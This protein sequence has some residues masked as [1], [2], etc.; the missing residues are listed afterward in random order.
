MT[1]R[2]LVFFCL[3][4][5][6]IACKDTEKTISSSSRPQDPWVFRSV[7]DLKPRMLTL[8]L[9]DKIWV[10]YHTEH[11][12]IYKA[13]NGIV[14][15]DGAV[16][17]EQHGPQP[18]SIGDG[19]AVSKYE[20]PWLILENG[21]DTVQAIVNYKGHKFVGDHVQLMYEVSDSMHK[22]IALVTEEVEAIADKNITLQRTFSIKGLKPGIGLGLMTNVSS[23][24]GK[25]SIVTSGNYQ[26]TNSIER[27]FATDKKCL[28]IEGILLLNNGTTTFN[29]DFMQTPTIKNTNI[30]GGNQEK[31]EEG[32]PYG[33]TLISKSD[34]KT[35]HNKNLKTVG[36]SYAMIAEKYN[37]D[38]STIRSLVQK[39]K[40]GGNGVWGNVAM[41][42]HADLPED[43]IKQMVE[44]ILSLDVASDKKTVS[45]DAAKNYTHSTID[46]N[47]FLPGAIT[48]VYDAKAGIDKLPDFSKLKLK[49]AGIKNNFDN[50]DGAEF[51]DLTDNFALSAEGYLK[52]N[53]AGVYNFELWSD[54]GSKLYIHDELLIDN[55]GSHGTEGKFGKV[56]LDVGYHP[57]KMEYFQG[58]GGKYLSLDWTKPGDKAAEVIP[59]ENIFHMPDSENEFSKY[60][61]PMATASKI[62]GNK[63]ILAGV[64][65]AFTLTQARPTDFKPKVGGMDFLKDGSL[66]V[67]TWDKEGAVWKISNAQSGNP[68][69][70]KAT[71]IAFGLA[72]PL[73]VKVVDDTIYVMQKQEL[74]KLVDTNGDGIMDEYLTL[75]NDW[76]VS[77]NFHEFGFGLEYKDG[78]FYATLA[79]A[80]VPGG[81]SVDPQMKDRG[82]VIKINKNTGALSFIASGLRTPNGIGLGYNNELFVADNQGDWLPSSKIVHITDGA[83]YGSRSVDPEGTKLL[84]EKPPVVWLPQDEIGNSP[85]TPSYINVGPYK[86]QMI[87]GEVTHGGIK[88]VFVEEVNGVL[89]GAVFRFTQGLEAGVNRIKWGPDGALYIGGIGNPGNWAQASK[90]WYG[91]QRLAY[92][93]KSVFEMLAVRAKANGVE[94]EFTEPL[95]KGEGLDPKNYEILQWYYKPTIAYGGPKLG[96]A[97]LPVKSVT[98]SDDRKKV[99]LE[100]SGLKAGH[101]VYVHLI[102]GIISEPGNTLWS[103]EAWYTM[104]ELSKEKG[105][106]VKSTESFADNSLTNQEKA[107]GWQ[108]LFDGKKIDQFKNFRKPSIGSGWVI[109]D[110]AIHLNAVKENG[111][112]QAKDGGD[113]ITKEAYENYELKLEW[114]ITNCGN[115][116]IIFNV[117]ESEKYDYVWQTGPEMQVLDNTCHP[118]SR[119][120]SHRAG[121]L[122]DMIESI[123]PCAKPA[124]EWNKVTI[125]NYK[126]KVDFYLNGYKTVSF[127]MHTDDWKK[128][129]AKSKF[130]DM[131]GFGLAKIGHIALQDHGDKVWY[132]NIKIKKLT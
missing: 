97:K 15:F 127:T 34:C 83:W 59:A 67:S 22:V 103:T 26:I 50:I 72:E 78:F 39:V 119:Y 109:N 53:K 43:D 132:K 54:D 129:V 8:A 87:H 110:N 124:G 86:G 107:E 20:K 36:P 4:L 63:A 123:Y 7:L 116:G 88:R 55:D 92:N 32:L 120:I 68:S 75:C 66:I 35:C 118:D 71:R 46:T 13:W 38:E 57:F 108:L 98:I 62:P 90:Q 128:M 33:A 25:E 14:Y 23:I 111:K 44:Y 113:I 5:S 2:L 79:T 102:N 11:G 3:T 112:W 89:Q 17:T 76:K 64:H 74:T 117:V 52:I 77:S 115:S 69:K 80:I 96:E 42:A 95:S 40:N 28:D 30:A 85:S 82:K 48:K 93:G 27:N 81:A 122:Y 49:Q 58:G 41:S 47:Q 114:K 84:K 9:N 1:T 131:P 10:A 61:L 94:I 106:I 99:F 121:D 18:L 31:E 73:G 45:N 12:A 65:P 6:I 70:M 125:R 21:K 19:Y 16:Y 56:K 37:S 60:S 105:I 104:N 100:L 51:A 101:V 29:V 130:K 24:V 91:L 126:G